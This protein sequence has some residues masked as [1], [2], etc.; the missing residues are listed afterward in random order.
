MGDNDF[1]FFK[2]LCNACLWMLFVV[3]MLLSLSS[4]LMDDVCGVNCVVTEFSAHV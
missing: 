4:L 1:T 2:T 3:L